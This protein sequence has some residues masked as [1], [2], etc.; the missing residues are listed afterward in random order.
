MLEEVIIKK[1]TK[2]LVIYLK[3]YIIRNFLVIDFK[4]CNLNNNYNIQFKS[5]SIVK[6]IIYQRLFTFCRTHTPN[7]RFLEIVDP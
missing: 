1:K 3:K 4:I 2:L 5:L 7:E 6:N